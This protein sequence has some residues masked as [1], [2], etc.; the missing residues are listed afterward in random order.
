MLNWHYLHLSPSVRGM[1]RLAF[2]WHF[3]RARLFAGATFFSFRSDLRDYCLSKYIKNS[4]ERA[5]FVRT[6]SVNN[7]SQ[8]VFKGFIIINQLLEVTDLK[9]WNYNYISKGIDSLSACI[10]L[11]KV[12]FFSSTKKLVRSLIYLVPWSNVNLSICKCT[13]DKARLS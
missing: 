12:L 7:G 1:E 11:T 3:I 4:S 10:H 13:S 2:R 5:F 8:F 6:L 9:K